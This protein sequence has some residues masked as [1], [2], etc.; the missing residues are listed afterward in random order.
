M[1][2]DVVRLVDSDLAALSTGEEFKAA[3]LL[4][5]KAWHQ[6]PAASLPDDDRMLAHLAGFGRDIKAWKKVR[7]VALRGFERCDDGRLYH[8]VIAEKVNDAL[9]AKQRQRAK[10]A[11]ATAAR[12]TRSGQRDDSS[13]E[14]R[15]E[16]RDVLRHEHRNEVQ[17]TGTVDRDSGNNTGLGSARAR[18]PLADLEA[19]LRDAAGWQSEPAPN[20]AVTGPI[21]ALIEAGADLEL[22]VLPV[23]RAIA[24]QARKRTSWRYFV[25]AIKA[26]HSDRISAAKLINGDPPNGQRPRPADQPGVTEFVFATLAGRDGEGTAGVQPAGDG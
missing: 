1:P 7:E 5:C 16:Q 26:A 13:E 22:D 8:P 18:E 6:V 10:T 24:G 19:T 23:V 14:N 25:D 21:H 4:W 12:K 17:G 15:H 20:L 2:L 9:A 11:N 3:V